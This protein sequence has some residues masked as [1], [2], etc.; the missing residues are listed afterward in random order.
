MAQIIY[1]VF[2]GDELLKINTETLTVDNIYETAHEQRI[3]GSIF[4]VKETG[5]FIKA[6][7]EK[8]EVA[9]GDCIFL[10]Y[11]VSSV[12]KGNGLFKEVEAIIAANK[13]RSAENEVCKGASNQAELSN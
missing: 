3:Y 13:R 2:R 8:E 11:E 4:L 5:L 6:N 9:I 10:N 1:K 12:I 7:G